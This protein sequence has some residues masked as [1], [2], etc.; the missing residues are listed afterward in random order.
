[1]WQD[2]LSET[3]VDRLHART[4]SL[5]PQIR[6]NAETFAIAG[7]K[8]FGSRRTGDQIAGL[9]SGAHSLHSSGILAL[10]EA[11]AWL[12]KQDWADERQTQEDRD[13]I[14]CCQTLQLAVV[15]VLVPVG[16]GTTRYDRSI[17]EL[18]AVA[19]GGSADNTISVTVA[20]DTLARLGI[21]VD[22]DEQVHIANAHPAIA[23]LLAHTPW[24]QNWHRILRRLDGATAGAPLRFA[25][26]RIR[27]TTIPLST[28]FA[29]E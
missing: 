5:I 3:Y 1:M 12:M 24:A 27:V 26:A 14:A 17:G 13:E 19:A 28:L 9:I 2:T 8:V 6:A 10:D 4:I 25:G 15:P 11:T 7:A 18:I 23:D 16:S 20:R 22:D 29:A 21:R